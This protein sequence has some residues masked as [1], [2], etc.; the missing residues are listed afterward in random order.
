MT[1]ALIGSLVLWCAF[2]G[3][4]R[5]Q[6]RVVVFDFDGPRESKQLTAAVVDILEQHAVEVVSTKVANAQARRSTASPGVY[7]SVRSCG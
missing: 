7:A 5:A 2:S 4:A 1:R 3:A 6:S